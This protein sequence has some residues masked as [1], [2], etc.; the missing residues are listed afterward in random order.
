MNKIFLTICGIIIIG[1]VA[2]AV[3]YSP[4]TSD[5]QTIQET[6]I[7][8]SAGDVGGF[9]QQLPEDLE[10]SDE[11]REELRAQGEASNGGV[12]D[13]AVSIDDEGFS[14]DTLTVPAVTTVVF[15]NNGQGLHWPASDP[16]PTHTNLSA[17]DSKKGLAT[18]ETFSFTFEKP[19][20]YT[21]H[22]HLTASHKATIIVQ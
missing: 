7:P 2:Y 14:P 18:G 17:L 13:V 4:S 5:Q 9:V 20:T 11:L 3:L 19:G 6:P 15:T 22:D 12:S 16:H 10:L 1:A 8:Q 21:M